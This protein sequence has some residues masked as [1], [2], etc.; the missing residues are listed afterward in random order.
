L[1]F[2]YFGLT[3]SPFAHASRFETFYINDAYREAFVALRYGI[4]LRLGLVVLTGESGVGK[5]SL[6]TLFRNSAKKNVRLIVL[7]ARERPAGLL[8]RILAGLA[9]EAPAERR[10]GIQTLNKFLLEQSKAGQIVAIIIDDADELS[11]EDFAEIKMLLSLRSERAHLLQIV[12]AGSPALA[13][14]GRPG[15]RSLR[16]RV[17]VW[18]QIRP[19][20]TDEV[21]AYIEHKLS[22]AGSVLRG[23]FQAGAVARIAAYSHGIPRTID[24]LCDRSLRLAYVRSQD[25]ITEP[26]VEDA[27]KLLQ[28]GSEAE[29]EARPWSEDLRSR[30]GSEP[31]PEATKTSPGTFTENLFSREQKSIARRATALA[32]AWRSWM[33]RTSLRLKSLIPSIPMSEHG[34]LPLVRAYQ[35][36][37]AILIAALAAA[38]ISRPSFDP[39]AQPESNQEANAATESHPAPSAPADEGSAVQTEPVEATATPLGGAVAPRDDRSSQLQSRTEARSG[40]LVYLHTSQPADFRTLE[41]IG[42]VLRSEGYVVRDT[43]FTSNSTQGDVRFFFAGDRRAAE[44]VKSV[45]EAELQTR[46]YSRRLQLLERDGRKFRFAAP[47]KIE[48]WLPPLTRSVSN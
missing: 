2:R 10:A 8:F 43:R 23:L 19:L 36:V 38:V 3:R 48:V 21:E 35:T 25:P 11:P 46:G 18:S 41:D 15:L 40:E 20:A 4:Q 17:R 24:A 30:S 13:S 39:P 27:W 22:S 37:G 31:D 42:A 12:L 5:T 33:L 45:V 44:R 26:I 32:T 9:L 14:L 28:D 47:R 1:Y 7:S 29:I 34:R 6:I 16:Q